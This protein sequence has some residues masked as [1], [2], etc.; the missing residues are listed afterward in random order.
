MWRMKRWQSPTRELAQLGQ[1]ATTS[2]VTRWK[3]RG[4]ARRETSRWSHIAAQSC[5]AHVDAVPAERHA[6][7]LEARALA[8]ALRQRAVGAH[9]AVPREVGVVVR[10]EHGAGEARRAAARR[11]RSCGR[12][13]AGS[14]AR[15]RGPPRVRERADA[16]VRHD[17]LPRVRKAPTRSSPAT[18]S[19]GEVGV[20]VQSHWF[21]VGRSSR[22]RAPGVGAVATQSIGDRRTGRTRST[23]SGRR[24]APR[25]RSRGRRRR[26]ARRVPPG[27]GRR[28]ARPRGDAHRGVAASRTPAT[29][30]A[31]A[32]ASRRT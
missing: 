14:R 2:S 30:P 12:S 17:T 8:V 18:R 24:A 26:R 31:T 16:I 13:P 1:R 21:S 5:H 11:R 23:C 6:L 9:D 32:T 3:P 22:G 28:R 19:P 27:R 7:G 20:A 29:R 4:R 15:A 25:R 10:V